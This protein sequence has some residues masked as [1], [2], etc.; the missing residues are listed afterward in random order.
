MACPSK[1]TK[2]KHKL[3][4]VANLELKTELGIDRLKGKPLRGEF[5]SVKLRSLDLDIII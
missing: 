1:Q 2:L 3:I 4:S 5:N